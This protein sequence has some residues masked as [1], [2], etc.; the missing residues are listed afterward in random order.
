[1]RSLAIDYARRGAPSPHSASWIAQ[2]GKLQKLHA[3]LIFAPLQ[4]VLVFAC[5]QLQARSSKQRQIK[6]NRIEPAS[7]PMTELKSNPVRMH[8]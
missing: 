6:S 5:V 3:P 1:V 7:V 2:D 8:P 4:L